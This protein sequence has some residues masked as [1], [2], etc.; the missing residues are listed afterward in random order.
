MASFE[1]VRVAAIQATPVILDAAATIE[2]AARLLHE[3]ADAGARLAV[4]PECFVS[5]YP[6][7]SWARGASSFSGWDEL[8]MRMWEESVDVPGPELDRLVGGL[9]GARPVLRDRRE[10]ARVRAARHALQHA[11]IPRSGGPDLKAPQADADPAG[12]ALPRDRGGRRPRRGAAAVRARGWPDLLGEPDA[13]RALRRLSR[14]AADL[15]RADRRRQRR[16]AGLDA[17]HRDR[18]GRVRHLRAAVHPALRVPGRL[19]G[20]ASGGGGLRRRRRGDRR[21]A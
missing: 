7:N 21:P 4:L 8:W 18:V 19:P 15:G 2:K 17:P 11:R 14:R 9:P 6:S 10:R 1:S 5:L 3:A 20:S 12:A 13:A 16:L